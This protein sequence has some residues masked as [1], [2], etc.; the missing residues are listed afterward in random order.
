MTEYRG[1]D[2]W[3]YEEGKDKPRRYQQTEGLEPPKPKKDDGDLEV[4][5]AS[6]VVMAVL[7][8]TPLFGLGIGYAVAGFGGMLAG[9]GISVVIVAV[10]AAVIVVKV[11]K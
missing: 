9:L 10:G 11:V 1:A 8:A 3:M 2:G 6:C 5:G 4:L 7:A